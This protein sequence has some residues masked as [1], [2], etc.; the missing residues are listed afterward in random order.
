M[1]LKHI[2][3]FKMLELE[4]IMSDSILLSNLEENL[5]FFN[6]MY[7]AIRL[8]DPINKKVIE[9]RGCERIETNNIC[10]DYWKTGKIC[11]NCIATRASINNKSYIKLEHCNN[12][13]I[14]VTSMPIEN[15]EEPT[16]L[17]LFKNAT[18]S[19]M[20]GT[21]NY[22]VGHPVQQV[23][24]EINDLIMKDE[25]TGLYNRRYVMDRL[26]ADIVRS[27]LENLPLSIIFM[28]IDNFKRINDTYG[29]INGDKMIKEVSSIILRYVRKELEWSARYGG[30]EFIISLNNTNS[31]AAYKIAE[32]IRSE[33]ADLRIS[34]YNN[35]I[36]TTVSIG[37][38]TVH[39]ETK[40]AEEI[41][42]MAD[43][44]MYEA[45]QRGKNSSVGINIY[46]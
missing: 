16:V 2:I 33:I 44:R 19:M 1:N 7:D 34:I 30:D 13:I 40:K 6:K 17:E 15:A 42:A 41:I 45:K 9:Y 3:K 8:V 11:D 4:E 35:T 24:T 12:E 26:P 25:P 29:H 32:E 5:L 46:N 43:S 21:G 14:M 10:Y 18:D 37:I 23:V 27:T 22:S 28:D 39:G 38:Y 20:I 31:D 36:Q